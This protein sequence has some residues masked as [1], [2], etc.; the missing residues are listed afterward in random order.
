LKVILIPTIL[1]VTVLVAGFFALMQVQNVST[2]HN[3]IQSTTPEV[4]LLTIP[5]GTNPADTNEI[6]IACGA[7]TASDENRAFAVLSFAIRVVSG[8]NDDFEIDDIEVRDQ[9]LTEGDSGALPDINIATGA[10]TAHVSVIPLSTKG[11]L[12]ANGELDFIIGLVDADDSTRFGA[13]ATILTERG[14]VCA[15]TTGTNT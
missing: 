14:S 1:A 4:K 7:T 12:S 13:T 2:V 9:F 11:I 10:Q 5:D 6:E 15:L 8:A 3:A